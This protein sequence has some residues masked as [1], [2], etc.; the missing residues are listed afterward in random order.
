M[1]AKTE[2]RLPLPAFVRDIAVFRRRTGGSSSRT[3]ARDCF[4][5]CRQVGSDDHVSGMKR[6]AELRACFEANRDIP[7]KNPK[8]V[9]A[10]EV[11][12]AE[13]SARYP[14]EVLAPAEAAFDARGA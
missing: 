10:L 2:F 7:K 3:K 9:R 13:M 11:G 5:R 4:R 1:K 14:G 12:F 6:L 8:D